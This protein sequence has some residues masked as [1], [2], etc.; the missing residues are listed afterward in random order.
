MNVAMISQ[1][2]LRATHLFPGGRL[3]AGLHLTASQ[4]GSSG[5]GHRVY[6][7]VDPDRQPIIF[8]NTKATFDWPTSDPIKLSNILSRF[9]DEMVSNMALS[10]GHSGV[11]AFKTLSFIF[12]MWKAISCFFFLYS[13]PSCS[14]AFS[15][16]LTKRARL[17]ATMSG[18]NVW[19]RN[20]EKMKMFS[21]I[22][23]ECSLEVSK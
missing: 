4:S 22:F 9:L 12:K 8:T 19:T 16:R 20:R 17:P 14:I 2:Q 3:G 5:W 15:S 7:G 23:A 21:E 6:R 13:H 18:S 11:S 1:T 10:L